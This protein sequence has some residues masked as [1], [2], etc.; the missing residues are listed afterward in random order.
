VRTDNSSRDPKHDRAVAIDQLLEGPHVSV[1]GALDE[2]GVVH[3]GR[4]R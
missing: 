1:T 3:H 4:Q 2:R